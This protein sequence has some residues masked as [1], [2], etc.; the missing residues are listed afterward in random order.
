MAK[1]KKDGDP[2]TYPGGRCNVAWVTGWGRG[3][4]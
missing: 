1:R 4:D 3:S 2:Y